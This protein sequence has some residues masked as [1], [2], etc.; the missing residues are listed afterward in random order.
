MDELKEEFKKQIHKFGKLEID[1]I[2]E[3]DDHNEV[4]RMSLFK[5]LGELGLAGITMP[6]IYQGLGLDF[7]FNCFSLKELAKYSVPY[8]VTLSVSSMVQ[9]IIFDFCHEKQKLKY[10]PELASGAEI[11]AFALTESDSGSDAAS[12]KTTAKRTKKGYLL[13][14]TKIFITSGSVAKTFI[15]MARTSHSGTQ[16]ISAFIVQKG[17]PGFATG[18]SERKMGWRTSPTTELI[19][20]N[21]L[22]PFDS[23]IGDEGEG[24]KV[25]KKGLEKGRI[26]IG[27]I[28]VG[29]A[30]RAL[31][32]SVK[33]AKGREQF[34]KPIFDLQGL[35][36]MMSDMATETM[37]SWSLVEAAAKAYDEKSPSRECRMLGSMAKLKATDTAMKVTTDA[38]QVFGGVGYTSE[39]P[40]ERYM[41]DAKVLQIVEGTNQIQKV[42][43]GAALRHKY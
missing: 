27:A 24:F 32:E 1:P 33:F 34:G 2:M 36:F 20:E 19:F 22:L 16:G 7:R 21:C 17:H 5:K 6:E 8:A 9:N 31:E 26:S 41:R 28:A 39:F 4:F 14:G 11:G 43:I 35:Q 25:A 18:K 42:L 13:N 38:V 12:L 10:L 37:A 3:E 40:V 23:L 29:L 30:E 15:V